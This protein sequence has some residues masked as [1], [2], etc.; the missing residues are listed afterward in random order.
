MVGA[1][2]IAAA[3][4]VPAALL[5]RG[6]PASSPSGGTTPQASPTP[7]P[8][9]AQAQA[10]YK[11]VL[12]ASEQSDGFRYVAVSTPNGGGLGSETITGEA[13]QKDGTQQITE[14][15]NYGSEEFSLILTSNQIV[16]FQGNTP[17]L[18]DQL[19]VVAGSAA[20]LDGKWIVVAVGDGPYSQLE[21]GITTT[22]Q[23]QEDTFLPTATATVRG[24]GGAAL[25]KVSGTVPAGQDA[26]E[27]G[28]AYFE[29][30]SGSHLPTIYFQDTNG[31]GTLTT[32]FS[33]WGQ[34]PSASP[35]S[36]SQ[37]WST[38]TTSEPPDGYGSGQPGSPSPAPSPTPT[39]SPGGPV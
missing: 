10:L 17:A 1:L 33:A 24:S 12:A 34:A 8:T 18:E 14:I 5:T 19:G 13:G 16:Y 28:S 30:P 4:G 35:P 32:T 22:S 21:V 37:A 11:Q 20:A 9:T 3:V 31:E 25:T 26:P 27:G 23:M 15:S 7:G 38:L 2:V 6:S 36:S 39:P 29:L